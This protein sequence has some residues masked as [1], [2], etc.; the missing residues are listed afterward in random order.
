MTDPKDAERLAAAGEIYDLLDQAAD[1]LCKLAGLERG[2]DVEIARL[3]QERDTA[4]RRAEALEAEINR[5]TV[6]L[7][8]LDDEN[9]RFMRQVASLQAAPPAADHTERAQEIVDKAYQDGKG[10]AE[11]EGQERGLS[12]NAI[13]MLSDDYRYENLC[14]GLAAALTAAERAGAEKATARYLQDHLDLVKVMYQERAAKIAEARAEGESTGAE[15]M[16]EDVMRI[17]TEWL[18]ALTATGQGHSLSAIIDEV[19]ALAAAA[20]AMGEKQ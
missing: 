6:R 17:L 7:V 16:Q 19:R 20:D 3:T 9:Q 12:G 10:R 13:L 2:R 4:T 18:P 15:K 5:L 8:Q 14:S 11:N 1:R